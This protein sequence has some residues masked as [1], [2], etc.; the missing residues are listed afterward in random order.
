MSLSYT[1]PSGI[2]SSIAFVIKDVFVTQTITLVG[3][4][5]T[6]PIECQ[7]LTHPLIGNGI[8]IENSSESTN[9]LSTYQ[10]T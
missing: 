1:L 2:F 9:V 8:G 6:T 7:Q 4:K 5:P 3:Q 10:L